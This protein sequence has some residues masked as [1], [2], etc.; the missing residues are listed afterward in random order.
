MQIKLEKRRSTVKYTQLLSC[1]VFRSFSLNTY[2]S[3]NMLVTHHSVSFLIYERA[4]CEEI[5]SC[6]KDAATFAGYFL[7]LVFFDL[8]YMPL[9]GVQPFASL[10]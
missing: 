7:S 8:Y 10:C 3:Q 4:D 1:V 2:P 5:T 9:E 6:M